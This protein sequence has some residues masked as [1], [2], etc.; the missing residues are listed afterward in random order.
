ME[1]G[2][3]HRLLKGEVAA[4][5]MTTMSTYQK[6]NRKKTG[7]EYE[8]SVFEAKYR[9]QPDLLK[10]AKFFPF[11]FKC[12]RTGKNKI[13]M[14]TRIYDQ[15]EGVCNFEEVEG[16]SVRVDNVVDNG[17][18]NLMENQQERVMEDT[19]NMMFEQIRRAQG[20]TVNDVHP[21][22][23]EAPASASR[24][25]EAAAEKRKKEEESSDDDE[26]LRPMERAL[27]WSKQE[28]RRKRS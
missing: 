8:K 1:K 5:K 26:D 16:S 6:D 24:R 21:A 9:S 14:R 13:E 23:P 19:S 20:L 2:E 22:V 18:V 3:D 12:P 27:M 15:A 28:I 10:K 11:R 4:S 7:V 17:E 25:G